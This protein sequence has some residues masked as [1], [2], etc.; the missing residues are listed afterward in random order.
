MIPIYENPGPEELVSI[1]Q[2]PSYDFSKIE[3]VVKPILSKVQRGG[4]KALKK[5]ALE[6]DHVELA[7][8]W[9]TADEIAAAEEQV[10]D[11]LKEAIHIARQNIEKFHQAQVQEDLVMEVMPGV[12]CSRRSVPVQKVGLYIPGGSAPLFSTVLMLAIPASIAG[13]E[14]IIISSPTNRM[15]EINPVVLYTANLIGVKRI[16]KLG[17]AQ[18]I[19]AMAYGTETVP[20]VDKI[21]G[22][23]N[24]YVTVAKQ[25]VARQDVA[26]DMPAGPSEVLV[27]VDK[28]A[29][30]DFAASDLLSQAEH[31]VDSQVVLV[32]TSM[33]K[34]EEVNRAV[35]LQL[36]GLSRNEIAA[37]ALKKSAIIVVE[38]KKEA[39]A[40]INKYG[41]EHLIIS[42]KKAEKLAEKVT[43]S[44]SVFVGPYSPESVGDYA[45]GTNHTLPTNGW[46]SAF[47]GVSLDSFVKKITYQ[48]L[49]A[50][51]LTLLGPTVERMAE[52]EHLDAHK[53]A[54]TV[55]LKKLRED[56]I[57]GKTGENVPEEGE[58][59]L[60]RKR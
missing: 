38:G 42:T 57:P 26:I 4:D 39:L 32:S 27:V 11:T 47:S 5:F 46:A 2:R 12:I 44:G 54:V 7:D 33:K 13:C 35:V 49:S 40:I 29:D 36:E 34:A 15:G 50:E 51:G 48:R 37:E 30:A 21:F 28:H 58:S 43:N 22:P 45:S 52:A 55:R 19:A 24:Q 17:G 23:G 31:G 3:K 8:L 25:V 53:N 56:G 6:Y 59:V 1:L 10:S 16:L 41:P 14:E 9:A 18:A 20:K 60:F